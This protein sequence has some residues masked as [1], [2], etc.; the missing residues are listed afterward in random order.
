[1]KR[2]SWIQIIAFISIAAV[3]AAAQ[4]GTVKGSINI[5][6]MSG[7]NLGNFAC[8][9]LAV[10]VQSVG[11]KRPFTWSERSRAEG[12]IKTKRCDYTVPNV[13]ANSMFTL[14]VTADFPNSCDLKTF[15]T[16]S[17]FPMKISDGQ[18]MRYEPIVYQVACTLVK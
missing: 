1:M 16:S 9:N 14:S 13:R 3:A 17:S 10:G 8:S 7:N 18:V 5:E 11:K 4:T 6:N 15:K 2:T 12:Q